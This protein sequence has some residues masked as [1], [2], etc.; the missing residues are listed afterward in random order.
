MRQQGLLS[1]VTLDRF[2]FIILF[3]YYFIFQAENCLATY[4]PHGCVVVCSVDDRQ[5]FCEADKILQYLCQEQLNKEKAVILVANKV[6]L[7]RARVVS[8]QG[9]Y[10][11]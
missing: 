4:E 10:V 6:D 8:N 11:T 9:L 5:S 3:L 1:M 7:A 2:I